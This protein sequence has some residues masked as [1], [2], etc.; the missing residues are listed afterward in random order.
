M[1]FELGVGFLGEGGTCTS[2]FCS[3]DE[4]DVVFP[5]LLSS[6]NSCDVDFMVVGVLGESGPCDEADG[7]LG[8]EFTSSSVAG[9]A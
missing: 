9:R 6:N 1:G 2:S 7:E 4:T 8:N 3:R 5:L